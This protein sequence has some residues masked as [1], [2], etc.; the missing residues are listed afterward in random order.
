MPFRPAER[1][2]E[3]AKPMQP[4][5]DPAG[6]Y[7]GDLEANNDWIYELSDREIREVREAVAMVEA[8]GVNIKDICQDDFPLP[9]FDK[10]LEML[11][12]ELKEGRGFFLLR[13]VPVAEFTKHQAGIAFWG[14]GTRFGRAVSQNAKGHLL[15]H[16]KDFGGDYND[17][18]VRGYQTN[19][20]MTFHTDQCDYVALLCMTPA[21]S[22]GASRIASTVTLYNEMLEK[23]PELAKELTSEFY[24]TRHGEIPPDEPAWYK[25]PVFSFHKGYFS[26]RGPGTH[27]MKAQNL[28]GVPPFT[29]AQKDAFAAFR[30]LV[31]ENYFD[32][33]FRPGDIQILHS[34]VTVHTRT[35][36]QDWPEIERKRHLMRLWLQDI[37]GRPLVRGFR[38]NISGIEVADIP[39]TAPVDSLE[40]A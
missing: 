30:S 32:M 1:I 22:G 7:P 18:N 20:E 37:G 4:L 9:K 26:G 3:P 40:P 14:I 21:K 39:F 27:M 15:G 17:P 23:C 6:W 28:P 25:L 13:G 5:I 34:H 8:R 16:V 24:L 31:R 33:D 10:G 11:L 12:D 36:F 35:E 19:V 29:E 2:R 38:E